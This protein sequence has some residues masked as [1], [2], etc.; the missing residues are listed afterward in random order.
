MLFMAI[1]KALLPLLGG[2]Q[3]SNVS[4]DSDCTIYK[5]VNVVLNLV[6]CGLCD[7]HCS[8]R[9]LTRTLLVLKKPWMERWRVLGRGH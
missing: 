1:G 7:Y 5:A 6:I 4:S 2:K 9:A 8:L 3:P